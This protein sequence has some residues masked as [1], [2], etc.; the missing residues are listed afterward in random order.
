MEYDCCL[1]PQRV[2]SHSAHRIWDQRLLPKSTFETLVEAERSKI[3]PEILGKQ[4][5]NS[6][7]A[8]KNADWKEHRTHVPP[9]EQAK[10]LG[11]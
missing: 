5:Y 11:N 8:I 6:Y 7:L 9:R 4:I 2:G 1:Q 10:Y 3:L